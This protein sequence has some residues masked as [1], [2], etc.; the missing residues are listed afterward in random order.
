MPDAKLCVTPRQPR[1]Q[2]VGRS[3]NVKRVVAAHG[4]VVG[5]IDEF[6]P[7]DGPCSMPSITVSIPLRPHC[8]AIKLRPSPAFAVHNHLAVGGLGEVAHGMPVEAEREVHG[9][10]EGVKVCVQN[11]VTPGAACLHEPSEAHV[12]VPGV[13]LT[14]VAL[15]HVEDV[16]E[17]GGVPLEYPLTRTAD[18]GRGTAMQ[19]QEY[20]LEDRQCQRAVREILDLGVLVSR[21]VAVLLTVALRAESILPRQVLVGKSQ[22]A[23]GQPPLLL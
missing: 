18:V 10:E 23:V 12:R 16:A 9:V 6:V 11:A 3:R 8:T 5:V 13:D 17:V 2:R 22:L 14:V 4:H 1:P 21:G 7:H 20:V 15:R 19:H